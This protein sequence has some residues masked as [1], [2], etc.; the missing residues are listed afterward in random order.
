MIPLRDDV[1][2]RTFPYV[3]VTLIVLNVLMFGYELSLGRG[4]DA[5]FREYA[6]V[7]KHYVSDYYIT[8]RGTLRN[9][10]ILDLVVPLFASMFM[11]GGWM[12]II[13]NMVYLWIFGDN[14][15][16]RM[17]RVKFVIFYLLCGLAASGAHILSNVNS[18]VPSIGAS[19]AIAGVL[20]AYIVLYPRARVLVLVP[21][22][23]FLQFL[24]I[25]AIFF[26]GFWFLQNF[27]YGAISLG[28]ES[29]Q[30][31]GTAWWAHIGGF[32]AGLVMVKLFAT[33]PQY[34]LPDV[35]DDDEYRRGY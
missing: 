22:F 11:H 28:A 25:P 1:P 19:G 20:G 2:S 9:I 14:V 12:H 5:F 4:L 30:T 18:R 7:P 34:Y 8:P 6:V 15:E 33:K 17:G 35:W 32:V 23:I 26:I 27:F 3:T 10:G 16:D 29:A 24:E 31:S 13:G 21:I